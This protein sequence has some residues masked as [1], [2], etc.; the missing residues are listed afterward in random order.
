MMLDVSHKLERLVV[1]MRAERLR[2]AV[3]WRPKSDAELQI[4][5][6]LAKPLDPRLR[7]PYLRAV[8]LAL[9]AYKPEQLGPGLIGRV[10][11][12]LQREFVSYPLA[13]RI[14]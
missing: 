4:I 13:D 9:R 14:R 7:D 5:A 6:E 8:V 3:T 12:E 11:R 1:D 2:R 10:G